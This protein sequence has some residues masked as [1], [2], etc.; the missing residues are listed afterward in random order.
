MGVGVGWGVGVGVGS[1]VGVGVGSGVGVGVGSGVGVGVDSGVGVAVG[2]GVGVGVGSGVEVGVAETGVGVAVGATATR[3][4]TAVGVGSGVGVGA[5]VTGVA[6]AVGVGS[7][8]G[9]TSS[10]HAASTTANSATAEMIA[11]RFRRVRME[12]TVRCSIECSPALVDFQGTVCDACAAGGAS[13]ARDRS[14][15]AHSRDGVSIRH[16]APSEETHIHAGGCM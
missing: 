15:L 14:R 12:V 4:T 13:T 3:V 8:A 10:P 1:G 6:V 11:A 16:G 9:G 5:T 7:G 2:S